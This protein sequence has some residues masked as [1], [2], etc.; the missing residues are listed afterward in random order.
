MKASK[1]PRP[2]RKRKLSSVNANAA[3]IDIGSKFH[4]VAVPADRDDEPV[5]TFD[6]FTGSLHELA[7]WLESCRVNTVA[8]ES[9]GI[10][11]IPLFAILDARGIEVVVANAREV[12]H[13]PGRKTDV[14][15][16][17]WLQQLHEYGLLRGSFHPPAE[18][19]DLRAY[20]RQRERLLDY[21]GSHV[22]HMQK[23]MMQMNVQLHHVVS[24][25]TGQTG[26]RIIRA[27]LDGTQDPHTLAQ[28][29]DRRCK[30]SVEKITKALEGSYTPEHLFALRQAVSLYDTYGEHVRECDEQIEAQLAGLVA[31]EPPEQ[32]LPKAR[33]STRQSNAPEFD[34]RA[35]LY[36]VVGVDLTQIHGF[37]SYLALKMVSECGT[38]LSKWPSA[39]HFTSWLCL[40]PGNKVSGGKLLSAHTRKSKNRT[41]ALLR[42]AALNVGKTDSALGAFYRRLAARV[43]K[44]KA[45]TAT[46]RKLA[47]LFYN[48]MRYGAT[49]SDPGASYYEE[50]HRAR[51]VSNLQ[52]RAHSLG[53]SV[54]PSADVEVS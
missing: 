24:D 7:A 51:V 53:L 49:Y 29:R 42:L 5:R 4:V 3:G 41:G 46:A 17:Q 36:A 18:I 27:I 47:I 13:V 52:R 50:R 35:A 2:R 11:W 8:I 31:P 25:I 12:K 32:P 38:D 48:T 39:K 28:L 14:N 45:I 54:A 15:D 44:S 30:S 34:V 33:H 16:A 19:A 10:Y 26:M 23:A 40:A 9:T 21:R 22:Q 6:S 43:G 37:G 20:L 1:S